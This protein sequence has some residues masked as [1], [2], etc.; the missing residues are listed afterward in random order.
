MH[1]SGENLK[2][3]INDRPEWLM[4]YTEISI[5]NELAR[6]IRYQ[7]VLI[8]TEHFPFDTESKY[9]DQEGQILE[10]ICQSDCFR[11]P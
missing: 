6:I 7:I 1:D 11:T 8:V 5:L 2:A 4:F 9:Q 3:N 10:Y